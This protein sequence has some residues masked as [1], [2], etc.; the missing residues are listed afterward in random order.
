MPKTTEASPFVIR[1]ADGAVVSIP[2]GDYYVNTKDR[3]RRLMTHDTLSADARRV[4]ACLELATMGYRQELAITM[5]GGR[6]RPLTPGD[7][8][9]QTGLSRQHVR[10][11]L[12]ELED[13]GLA[14]R[15]SED[16][17]ALRRGKIVIYC[18]ATPRQPA[19]KVCSRAQLQ[20]PAWFPPEWEALKPYI[21]RRKLLNS[22]DE[23]LA[24]SYIQEGVKVGAQLQEAEIVA[25]RFL[26]CICAP[27]LPNKEERKERKTTPPPPAPTSEPEPQED[28]EE[29]FSNQPANTNTQTPPPAE[30]VMLEVIK[31][32]G[33]GV[34]RIYPHIKPA[35]P[36]A[37]AGGP[38][39]PAVPA[40]AWLRG[41]PPTADNTFD[42][43]AS[44]YPRE[45][46]DHAPAAAQWSR[47][48]PAQRQR[49]LDA[50]PK[51]L[52]CPRWTETP[53][54]IPMCSTWLRKNLYEYE[55]D[56]VLRTKAN[57]QW[58]PS[59]EEARRTIADAEA[60]LKKTE[61]DRNGG[62]S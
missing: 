16:G 4:Y 43:L 32:R 57:R 10:Y 59:P 21:T 38:A 7:I 3:A 29:D 26:E 6:K 45:K 42:R 49:A 55:P 5:Q 24:R 58:G 51:Y 28:E 36:P 31:P 19:E 50:L 46:F 48:T 17:G 34:Q 44:Q 13:A 39:V 11:G 40:A 2:P 25:A 60:R 41:D 20:T 56:P 62:K 12:A 53:D 1:G 9:Q 54:Y 61:P 8:S 37:P 35:P 22:L 15:R 33:F 18:W 23:E 30:P 47:K 14:E 52:T 27:S